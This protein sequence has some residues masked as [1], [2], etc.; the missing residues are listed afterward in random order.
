MARATDQGLPQEPSAVQ[1]PETADGQDME[2]T[3][4]WGW[5]MAHRL[6]TCLQHMVQ[7]HRALSRARGG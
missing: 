7:P 5:D 4:G 2:M 6:H 3:P 1:Q